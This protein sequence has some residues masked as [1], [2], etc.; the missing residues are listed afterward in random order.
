MSCSFPMSVRAQDSRLCF[1]KLIHSET[2]DSEITLKCQCLFICCQLDIITPS[3]I[4]EKLEQFPRNLLIQ[5]RVYQR[6]AF[7]SALEDGG[8]ETIIFWGRLLLDS[9]VDVRFSDLLGSS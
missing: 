1:R 9:W 8:G 5:V 2:Q 7:V 6:E 4:E 3:I